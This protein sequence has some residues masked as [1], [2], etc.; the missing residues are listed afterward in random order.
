MLVRNAERE[1]LL[2]SAFGRIAGG[3][4]GYNCFHLCALLQFYFEPYSRAVP[5]VL[6]RFDL[7]EK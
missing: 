5:C 6:L 1:Q 4:D 7:I 2:R 3:K